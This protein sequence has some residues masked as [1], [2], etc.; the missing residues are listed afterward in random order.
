MIGRIT[1]EG[2]DDDSDITDVYVCSCP[3]C[4]HST[5]ETNIF[6]HHM[7]RVYVRTE[8]RSPVLQYPALTWPEFIIFCHCQLT[9]RM[10]F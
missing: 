10:R 5:L 6:L 7:K 4:Q 1:S 8:A 9:D 2:S 3:V